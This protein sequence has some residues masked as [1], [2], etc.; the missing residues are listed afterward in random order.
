VGARKRRQSEG[1]FATKKG[2]V[3][4]DKLH[5]IKRGWSN[6]KSV[7]N[8]IGNYK[9]QFNSRLWV[10]GKGERPSRVKGTLRVGG[11]YRFKKEEKENYES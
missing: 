5:L 6:T 9:G 1:I 8:K 3:R 10:E 11:S 7:G 4:R 2:W